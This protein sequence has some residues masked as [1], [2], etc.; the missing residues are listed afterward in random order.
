[1]KILFGMLALTLGCGSNQGIFNSAGPT[2]E[3]VTPPGLEQFESSEGGDDFWQALAESKLYSGQL[4]AT[5][6]GSTS[7]NG[8]APGEMDLSS[9]TLLNR[10]NNSSAFGLLGSADL[11]DLDCDEIIK[12]VKTADKIF[13]ELHLEHIKLAQNRSTSLLANNCTTIDSGA[14]LPG[15]AMDGVSLSLNRESAYIKPQGNQLELSAG[16]AGAGSSDDYVVSS[17]AYLGNEDSKLSGNVSSAWQGSGMRMRG[18]NAEIIIEDRR[19][20]ATSEG[21]IWKSRKSNLALQWNDDSI[22]S[23]EITKLKISRSDGYAKTVTFERIINHSL[24]NQSWGQSLVSC[25]S[26]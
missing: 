6:L 5:L 2:A 25:N 8:F 18:N 24:N 1:M 7:S 17:Y 26:K 14:A 10:V 20:E 11:A 3:W 12:Q 21:N 15:Y 23:T 9:C 13:A 19:N 4:S 16:L 22:V